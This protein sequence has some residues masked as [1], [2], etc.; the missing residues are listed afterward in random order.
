MVCAVVRQ[1]SLSQLHLLCWVNLEVGQSSIPT[2]LKHVLRDDLRATI[3]PAHS[4]QSGQ[5]QNSQNMN[6]SVERQSEGL[7]VAHSVKALA[8]H[9]GGLGSNPNPSLSPSS[10][11]DIGQEWG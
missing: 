6:F 2:C 5:I 10:C 11:V 8:Q 4:L 3:S 9:A 1:E 7:A